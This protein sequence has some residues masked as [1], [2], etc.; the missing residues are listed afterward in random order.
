M[1]LFNIKLKT[2]TAIYCPYCHSPLVEHAKPKVTEGQISHHELYGVR[3]RNCGAK[4]HIHESWA[5]PKRAEKE[6]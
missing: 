6:I 2:T 4:G 3:C 5:L 1:K